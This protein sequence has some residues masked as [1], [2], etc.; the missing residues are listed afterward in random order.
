MRKLIWAAA[1]VVAMAAA[2]CCSC[3]TNAPKEIPETG[4]VSI[5][6]GKDLTGWTG[7]TAMYGVDP[8]EPGILQCFP[9]R[10]SQQPDGL[11]ELMTE[12]TYRNFILRFDFVMP[13]NGN[14]GLGIRMLNAKDDAAYHAMCE[15]QLLDDGGSEYYDPKGDPRNLLDPFQ[16]T[17]SVYGV[18]PCRRDNVGR[19]LAGRERDFTGGGSYVHRPGMWNSEEVRVVGEEIEVRLNGELITKADLSQ[20]VGN[21]DTLD[22]QQHPGLHNERGSIGWLGHGHNVKWRNIRILELPD[23]AKMSDL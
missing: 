11:F 19:K 6:N 8:K 7:A 20:F 2:G 21:G 23:D 14:N 4:F 18:V 5:F 16:Y 17:G 10:R 9:E 1:G 13:P 12:K 15:L 3:A 22:H